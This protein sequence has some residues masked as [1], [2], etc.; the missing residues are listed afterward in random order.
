MVPSEI[1]ELTCVHRAHVGCSAS[2]CSKQGEWIASPSD[3]KTA[4]GI[5]NSMEKSTGT[6]LHIDL[7]SNRRPAAFTRNVLTAAATGA[8]GSAVLARVHSDARTHMIGSRVNSICVRSE[9]VPAV[10]SHSVPGCE[11]VQLMPHWPSPSSRFARRGLPR[12]SPIAAPISP[13]GLNGRCAF[14]LQCILGQGGI[15]RRSP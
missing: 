7:P 11:T 14:E 3:T 4:P 1:P 8:T 13:R 15:L 12:V 2:A 9:C 5:W 6:P 10:G